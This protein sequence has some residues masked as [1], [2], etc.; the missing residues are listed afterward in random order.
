MSVLVEYIPGKSLLHKL[1]PL[2]KIIWT[3]VAIALSFMFSS[4]QAIIAVFLVNVVI[5]V[6]CGVTKQLLPVIKGLFIFALILVLFQIFF[7]TEGRTLFYLIPLTNIGRVTDVGLQM[8]LVM[9]FRMLATVLP[10]P[11]LMMTTPMTDIVVVLVEKFKVPFKYAFMFITA[12]RFIPSFMA[13]ME[14]ILQAQMSRGYEADTKNPVKKMMIVIPLAIPLL[15][16][17]IKKTEKMAV[18]MEARGFGSGPRSS[19][20]QINMAGIDY[21]VLIAFVAALS[22]SILFLYVI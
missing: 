17:S 10:I 18:S 22:S 1:N 12:L 16:S 13:E 4:P 6:A 8:S 7:V 21:G 15:I 5:A 2:T 20:R 14:M 19:Y 9:A 11:V 3:F